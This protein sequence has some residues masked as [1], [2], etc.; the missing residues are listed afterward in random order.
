ML[1]H[2][3]YQEGGRGQTITPEEFFKNINKMSVALGKIMKDH[4]YIFRGSSSK[5]LRYADPRSYTRH[6]ANTSNFY[7]LI[8]DNSES[9]K[10]YPK[11]SQSLICTSDFGMA[12]HYGA[13]GDA[14]V[15]LP[16]GNPTIGLCGR[17]D[18]WVSF[19]QIEKI[20]GDELPGL[21][22]A[23][24]L[25]YEY[26][27][28]ESIPQQP[29]Y[30]D[31]VKMLQTIDQNNPYYN[32]YGD[33]AN[34]PS[35]PLHKI[36]SKRSGGYGAVGQADAL[37]KAGPKLLEVLDWILNPQRNKISKFELSALPRTYNN[38]LWVSAP[39]ITVPIA[40]FQEWKGQGKFDQFR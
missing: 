37:L 40:E 9:W 27:T 39:C 3:I 24:S 26:I 7:T 30:P 11:R 12:D 36:L 5:G 29:T 25:L 35:H 6:S 13:Q 34:D 14:F 15:V 10:G 2:E 21:N 31:F 4:T 17:P 28:S 22:R 16:Y 20:G 8:I 1:I 18:F 23:I 38:E 32:Q 33:P 19:P